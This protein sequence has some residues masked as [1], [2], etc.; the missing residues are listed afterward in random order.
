M[1]RDDRLKTDI[2]THINLKQNRGIMTYLGSIDA[3]GPDDLAHVPLESFRHWHVASF[4]LLEKMRPHWTGWFERV[5]RADKTISLDPNWDPDGKW[6]NVRELLPLV[7]VFLPNAA[8][9]MAIS[10]ERSVKAAGR[11]LS[12]D[13]PL[14][15]VK[16]GKEGAVAFRGGERLDPMMQAAAGAHIADTT[17]AGDSFDAGFLRA[18]LLRKPLERC[19]ELGVRCGSM[20]LSALGGIEAQYA[21][22]FA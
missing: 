14:V 18:W 13:C 20:S 6:T 1:A 12:R 4:F 17:G 11:S 7:D 5:R 19:L 8:E 16:C 22:E 21:G 3:V 10:G 9:A 15:V 2:S